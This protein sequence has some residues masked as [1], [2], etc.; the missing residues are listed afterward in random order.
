MGEDLG[1]IRLTWNSVKFMVFWFVVL[2]NQVGSY[3]FY[4]I[5]C[6]L[7]GYSD[8]LR[9]GRYGDRIPMGAR[10]STSVQTGRGTHPASYT[11]GTGS[12]SRV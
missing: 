7:R 6:Y 4:E 10:F 8:S 5:I 1:Y 3:P 2:Y 12:L 9:V 11:M